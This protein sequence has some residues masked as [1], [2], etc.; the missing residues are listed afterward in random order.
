M[1]TRGGD[2]LV[3]EDAGLA[4][5]K[6]KDVTINSRGFGILDVGWVPE[7]VVV[8]AYSWKGSHEKKRCSVVND[9]P[10]LYVSWMNNTPT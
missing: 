1:T 5:E 6:F 4:S 9:E 2:V 10:R 3:S 7:V 8:V